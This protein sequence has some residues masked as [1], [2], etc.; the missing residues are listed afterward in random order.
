MKNSNYNMIVRATD[1]DLVE[2]FVKKAKKLG[3]T[4]SNNKETKSGI[5]NIEVGHCISVGT[6]D[7]FHINWAKRIDYYAGRQ[8]VP[9]YDIQL[10]WSKIVSRL[11]EY[12]EAIA[13]E[14]TLE[15]DGYE[16]EIS[17]DDVTIDVGAT[18][19]TITRTELEDLLE[20]MDNL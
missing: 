16:V 8:I 19:V 5:E 13:E 10:D 1:L 12:A 2:A 14:D 7:K 20:R 6:S 9:V 17:E 18:S 11:E 3:L 15:I 4:V